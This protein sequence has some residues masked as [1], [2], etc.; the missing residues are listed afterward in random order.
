MDIVFLLLPG[1]VFSLLMVLTHTYLGVHVLARGIIFVDLALA[2]V[3]AFGVSIAFLL[4]QESH[5]THAQVY[6]LS[7]A[8]IASFAFA[9]LRRLRDKTTR[10][11]TIGCVYVVATALTIVILSRSTQGMEELKQMLNG[12]I[13]W[14]R[15]EEVLVLVAV[16]GVL[17]FLHGVFF[18]RFL[19][20]S[21]SE[22]PDTDPGFLWEFLFF[23]SF[24]VIIT[25]AVNFA[26]VLMVFAFLIIPAFSAS[27]L[28]HDPRK[29]ILIGWTIGATGTIAG[30]AMSYFFDLPT[31]A[32]TVSLLGLMPL[33][34]I[35]A[36]SAWALMTPTSSAVKADQP[37]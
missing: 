5:G 7:A 13:L 32:T 11:V 14:V 34:A 20:L 26:G 18:P 29:Q 24:A 22:N 31:G 25:L 8:L 15:W 30:L 19:A 1:L 23:A 21:I 4:G 10:E 2:Q 37:K 33:L 35:L 27:M 3:A 6:A 16:Y 17:S 12:N 36:R 28:S 9:G